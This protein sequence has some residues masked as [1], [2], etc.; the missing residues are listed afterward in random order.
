MSENRFCKLCARPLPSDAHG[1]RCQACLIL[2]ALP[3]VDEGDGTHVPDSQ[4]S[5]PSSTPAVPGCSLLER[6][7]EGGMGEVWAAEQTATGRKVAIK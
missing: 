6:I 5:A 4:V 3:P 2:A 1:D 7:G